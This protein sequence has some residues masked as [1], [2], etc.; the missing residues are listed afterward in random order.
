MTAEEL[1][2][3]DLSKGSTTSCDSGY[4]STGVAVATAAMSLETDFGDDLSGHFGKKKKKKK[5]FKFH[6]DDKPED[7]EGEM[8]AQEG[9]IDKTED[10]QLAARLERLIDRGE[11]ML[12]SSVLHDDLKIQPSSTPHQTAELYTY[13]ELLQRLYD[14]CKNNPCNQA[15]SE[16]STGSSSKIK[17]PVPAAAQ[18]GRFKTAVL[19]FPEILRRLE[20]TDAAREALH[21]HRSRQIQYFG[22]PKRAAYEGTLQI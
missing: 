8:K 7:A 9:D 3:L 20:A 6:T 13:D 1:K 4:T 11:Q 14:Q 17:L 19:N 2:N 18:V 5:K 12:H 21:G 10:A 22:L 16:K 15:K